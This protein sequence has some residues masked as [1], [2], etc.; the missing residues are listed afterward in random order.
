MHVLKC[1]KHWQSYWIPQFNVSE[2][3]PLPYIIFSFTGPQVSNLSV[4]F[5]LEHSGC[6]G[7]GAVSLAE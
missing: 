6:L 2:G 1:S 7:Y 5:S 3:N 4:K